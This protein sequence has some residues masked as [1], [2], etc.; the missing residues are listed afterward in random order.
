[1]SGD[2]EGLDPSF[3]S[4]LYT[5]E[6]LVGFSFH[7][8]SGK[9]DDLTSSHRDGLAADIAVAGGWERYRL[10]KCALDDGWERI[11]VYDRHIHLCIDT[12][13]PRPVIW[14]GKST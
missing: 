1:M 14:A 4:A 11:G 2:I 6:G 12:R 7:V 9:R 13:R 5:L 8:T 10:V 3:L